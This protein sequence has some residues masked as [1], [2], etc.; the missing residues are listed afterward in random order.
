MTQ[1]VNYVNLCY[2]AHTRLLARHLNGVFT[3]YQHE[4][5]PYNQSRDQKATT[6]RGGNGSY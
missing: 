6:N 4:K 1:G 5:D 3:Y 2:T